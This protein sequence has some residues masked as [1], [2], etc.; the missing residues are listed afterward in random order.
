MPDETIRISL[1]MPRELAEHL[2]DYAR[3]LNATPGAM[4]GASRKKAK[5]S[6]ALRRAAQIGL[7][8]KGRDFAGEFTTAR[9]QAELELR[10]R[11]RL[12]AE[13]SLRRLDARQKSGKRLEEGV[14]MVL[15][16]HQGLSLVRLLDGVRRLVGGRPQLGEISRAAWSL[17][18]AG[19]PETDFLGRAVIWS[20]ASEGGPRIWTQEDVRRDL[21]AA[22]ADGA[23]LIRHAVGG[24]ARFRRKEIDQRGVSPEAEIAWGLLAIQLTG[25]VVRVGHGEY[26]W[27]RDEE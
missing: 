2:E 1:E 10:D 25:E 12:L 6:E 7:A 8:H 15:Q 17:R 14:L 11:Q 27:A 18:R 9:D 26:E 13:E 3:E 24:R 16:G 4:V 23:D 19:L 20:L 5:R 22:A 21:T